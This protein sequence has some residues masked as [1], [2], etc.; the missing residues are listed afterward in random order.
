LWQN[1]PFYA[2]SDRFAFG[3]NCTFVTAACAANPSNTPSAISMSDGFQIFTG[4]PT[5]QNFTGTIL[6]QDLN[7]KHG[8]VQQF[9]FDIERQLPGDIVLTVGYA[10]SRDSHLLVYGNI[11]KRRHPNRRVVTIVV[12]ELNQWQMGIPI[13]AKVNDASS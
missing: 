7:F 4:P 2:E 3:G 11:L 13:T 8:R 5:P 10:G 12:G 9:N 1:P 6:A